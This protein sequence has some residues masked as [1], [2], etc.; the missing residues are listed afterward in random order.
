VRSIPIIAWPML[1]LGACVIPQASEPAEAP[2]AAP[3]VPENDDD[4]I[5]NGVRVT[6][7]QI[8]GV[9]QTYRMRIP[10]GSYW[11]DSESG[12]WGFQ[13]GPTVGFTRTGVSLGA[14]LRSD[15]SGGGDGQLTG[16]FING[17]EIHPD[18][19]ALLSQYV[20]LV[21]GRYWVDS[22]GNAGYEGLPAMVN[23]VD[24]AQASGHD[25][26][27]AASATG[28]PAGEGEM[29]YLFQ[30]REPPEPAQQPPATEPAPPA[31]E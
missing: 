31:G 18:D 22:E 17:R 7:D 1:A 27:F 5:V 19:R 4:V 3:A 20:N 6:A 25:D 28:Y 16:I 21:P 30:P 9:E 24:Q 11:Y 12:A 10:P 13:G 29:A 15:A 14:A 2:L 26:P 23:L 8:A